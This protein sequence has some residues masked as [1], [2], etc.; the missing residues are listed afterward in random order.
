MSV[1]GL[2]LTIAWPSADVLA[3]SLTG[4]AEFS[5]CDDLAVCPAGTFGHT[6]SSASGSL[7]DTVGGNQS[8]NLYVASG[9]A[10]SVSS[11]SQF[12]NSGNSAAS[13]AIDLELTPGTYTFSIFGANHPGYSQGLNLFF[14]GDGIAPGISVYAPLRMGSTEPP[15]DADCSATPALASRLLLVPGACSLSFFDGDNTVTLLDYFWERSD[16][17]GHPISFVGPTGTT[18]DGKADFVGEF[19]LQV[20]P[21]A[22]I[23]GRIAGIPE[24]LSLGLFGSGLVGLAWARLKSRTREKR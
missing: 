13:T 2:V 8:Y 18:S 21:G 17:A 6:N 9:P 23:E 15:I 5:T 11:T 3:T 4:L 14:D 19:T 10:A 7:W 1:R 24:P 20:T 16:S 22:G 12:L